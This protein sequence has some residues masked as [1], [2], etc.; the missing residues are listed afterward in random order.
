LH[1]R[2]KGRSRPSRRA[3]SARRLKW[4]RIS[5]DPC[6][7][8]K[9]G[10]FLKK[11]PLEG[12]GFCVR[13]LWNRYSETISIVVSSGHS[14]CHPPGGYPM[15]R[16]LPRALFP[17]LLSLVLLGVF[18]SAAPAGGAPRPFLANPQPEIK[19]AAAHAKSSDPPSK[20]LT[21]SMRADGPTCI[22]KGRRRRLAF[23]TAT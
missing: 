5:R 23:S 20:T 12:S 19:A 11:E 4:F 2:P 1:P 10:F 16:F 8:A 18:A 15:D 7:S 9:G 22:W 17:G 21:S 13:P 3:G 6:G 14:A